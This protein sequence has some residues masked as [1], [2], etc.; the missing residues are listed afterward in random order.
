MSDAS[1]RVPVPRRSIFKRKNTVYSTGSWASVG[2]CDIADTDIYGDLLDLDN[3]TKEQ[4][5]TL[6]NPP[7]FCR[8]NVNYFADHMPKNKY[9]L[10]T[11]SCRK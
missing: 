5:R 10:G 1:V 7:G 11:Q 2:T 6:F 3:M 9:F 8:T 4:Y